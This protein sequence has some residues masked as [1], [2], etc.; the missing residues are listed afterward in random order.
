MNLPAP[1]IALLCTAACFTA[2]AQEPQA[3]LE[4]PIDAAVP[5][6]KITFTPNPRYTV[7]DGPLREDGSLDYVA[8]LNGHFGEGVTPENNAFRGLFLIL[9]HEDEEPEIV[10]GIREAL[11]IK[12]RELADVP[13]LVHWR[14]FAEEAG[15]DEQT[16]DEYFDT[17]LT[18]P[19]DGEGGRLIAEWLTSSREAID[20]AMVEINKP[21]FWSPLVDW[22]DGNGVLV[23][24]YLPHLGNHR[25]L[26]HAMHGS[27]GF[28]IAEGD[29]DRAIDLLLAMRRLAWHQ[30][31]DAFL[32]GILVGISIDAKA[33]I[34]LETFLESRVADAE[35]LKRLA[36]GWQREQPRRAFADAVEVDELC[37]AL[38]SLMQLAA[39]RITWDGVMDGV[40][41]QESEIDQRLQD[42]DFD[43][44]RALR[45]IAQHYRLQARIQRAQTA[46]DF[47]RVQEIFDENLDREQQAIMDR[48]VIEVGGAR[49]FNPLLS[50]R[51]MTES[52]TGI[53]LRVITP[54]MSAA[55]KTEFR[56]A[57]N[58]QCS[59]TAL[60]C[61]RYR[62]D[63]GTYPETLEMLV[64]DYLAQ[65]PIDP[66]DGEP[67][68]YR[69]EDDGAA[70]IYTISTNLVDDGGVGRDWSEGD[71][72]WRLEL[73]AEE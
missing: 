39:G 48:L 27:V 19:Y 34:A 42:D 65:I 6:H 20:Q 49:V 72:A 37:F 68:R 73:P 62:L 21:R 30:S 47:M 56:F 24:I 36:A 25:N 61:E 50:D 31:Q 15:L 10:E 66:M 3:P 29:A 52:I 70:V 17:F 33:L 40:A 7:F 55:R 57:A 8:A 26:T 69:G 43:L 32:L 38:D 12:P 9:P 58:E 67:I 51:E 41:G 11:A 53:Y 28:A 2:A 23:S 13:R 35:A 54:A 64:P 46:A 63:H 59:I 16:A 5:E 45:M 4:A 14:E 1:L 18:G 44:D 71:Y 22:E 60:A